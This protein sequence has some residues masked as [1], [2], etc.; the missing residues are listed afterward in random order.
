MKAKTVGVRELKAT[1]SAC[2][3]RVKSGDTIVI[4]ERGR[5]IGQ[6][7]PI[8]ASVEEKLHKGVQ[9]QH[10]SWSGQKWKP[11]APG[12]KPRGNELVSDL[13]LDDR[14]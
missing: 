3:R 5:P 13:L 12:V 2:L 11:S 14:K 6:I 10:W 9:S 7:S 1:L 8:E 4:S